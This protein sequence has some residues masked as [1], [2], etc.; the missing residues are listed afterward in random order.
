[1]FPVLSPSLV[2]PRKPLLF[3]A[4]FHAVGDPPGPPSPPDILP[5][6]PLVPNILV[7]VVSARSGIL[8]D[9]S[10]ARGGRGCLADGTSFTDKERHEC[11]ISR[12]R[13]SKPDDVNATSS[14]GMSR[15]LHP[16]T[17]SPRLRL[18]T[19]AKTK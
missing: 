5:Y 19:T 2:T 12:R 17:P 11:P 4:T 8:R 3:T 6:L 18:P 1:M 14:K 10:L 15:D 13:S 16:K 7:R 9:D